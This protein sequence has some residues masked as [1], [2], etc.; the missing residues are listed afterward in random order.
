MLR[1]TKRTLF[2]HINRL[3][4]Y[5]D[6]IKLVPPPTILAPKTNDTVP[7]LPNLHIL[8][9]DQSPKPFG[10]INRKELKNKIENKI[11]NKNY[12]KAALF[13]VGL[14]IILSSYTN[15]NKINE[16]TYNGYLILGAT[17]MLAGCLL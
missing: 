6:D 3:A 10:F 13:V 17:F 11:E 15:K 16:K 9:F 12:D 4:K 7:K 2:T 1:Q 14:V 8:K 5:V